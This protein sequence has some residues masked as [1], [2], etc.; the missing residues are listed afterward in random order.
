MIVNLYL[1][2]MGGMEVGL[3][4]SQFG[5]HMGGMEVNIQHIARI[6]NIQ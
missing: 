1:I 6:I 5:T 3:V 2:H 4:L